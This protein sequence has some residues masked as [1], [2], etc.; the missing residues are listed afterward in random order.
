MAD[1]Y[2][3]VRVTL[4]LMTTVMTCSAAVAS[5]AADK[6]RDEAADVKRALMP[7]YYHA[8]QLSP[9]T[10]DVR[11]LVP[12]RDHFQVECTWVE[13]PKKLWRSFFVCL[14]FIDC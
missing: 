13:W 12:G 6:S 8:P 5:D 11:H 10:A 14:N 7:S 2:V 9:D 3:Q 4:T 1:V